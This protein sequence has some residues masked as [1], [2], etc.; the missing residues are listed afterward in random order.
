MS[1]PLTPPAQ[2][3]FGWRFALGPG[4][5]SPAW[6]KVEAPPAPD[7]ALAALGAQLHA[8]RLAC[9]AALRDDEHKVPL[10]LSVAERRRLAEAFAA[11]RALN[12]MLPHQKISSE[13]AGWP[14]PVLPEGALF[15]A[16]DLLGLLGTA[17]HVVACAEDRRK[18]AAY[19]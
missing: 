9:L 14:D 13:V 2:E 8:L 6:P 19:A 15:G 3:P 10:W 12:A 5:L 11:V 1:R 17:A 4:P 18:A 7:D 16:R